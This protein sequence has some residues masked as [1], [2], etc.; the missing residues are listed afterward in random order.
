VPKHI[1]YFS[2]YCSAL[3]FCLIAPMAWGRPV[4]PTTGPG[5]KA[6]L[7]AAMSGAH[8]I[9][10]RYGGDESSEARYT[11]DYVAFYQGMQTWGRYRLLPTTE[12][13]D[14]VVVYEAFC[15]NSCSVTVYD[16]KTMA[17]IGDIR[18]SMGWEALHVSDEK[19][20]KEAA[21]FVEALMPYAGAASF[22]VPSGNRRIVGPPTLPLPAWAASFDL[23][24]APSLVEGHFAHIFVEPASNPFQKA[25]QEWAKKQHAVL[26]VDRGLTMSQ[27]NPFGRKDALALFE[28]DLNTS[29]RY[30]LVTTLADAD[31][32]IALNA[33]SVCATNAYDADFT[34]SDDMT[35]SLEDPKTLRVLMIR[36]I[37][38][39]LHFGKNHADYFLFSTKELADELQDLSGDAGPQG[40]DGIVGTQASST[41][42]TTS[43]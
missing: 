40:P 18:R 20:K 3:M 10:L 6:A 9:F 33:T 34:C 22:P 8:T 16:G 11:P 32:A 2:R 12:G 14:L 36:S 38:P 41:G 26:I 7:T 15:R 1:A 39:N 23:S 25:F 35:M 4:E 28:Q 31:F 42:G 19:H 17:W 43:Q 30:K 27:N 24:S 21:K 5:S 37:E 13:A 29:G